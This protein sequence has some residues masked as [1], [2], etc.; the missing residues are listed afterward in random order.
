[1]VKYRKRLYK[2]GKKSPKGIRFSGTNVTATM[3]LDMIEAAL[4]Y[5]KQAK[6][7]VIVMNEDS[8]LIIWLQSVQMLNAT[9]DHI[10]LSLAKPNTTRT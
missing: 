9:D 7:V 5:W 2:N 10:S 3:A 1:M 8:G 4:G 6:Q